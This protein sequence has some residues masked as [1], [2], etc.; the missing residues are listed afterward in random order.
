MLLLNIKRLGLLGFSSSFIHASPIDLKPRLANGL[1][2]TP[3]MGL[4]FLPRHVISC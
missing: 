3:P 1:A 4:D 2:I